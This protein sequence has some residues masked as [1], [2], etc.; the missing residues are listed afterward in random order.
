ML[1]FSNRNWAFFPLS[2]INISENTVKMDI[3]FLYLCILNL[4]EVILISKLMFR[5]VC[6]LEFSSSCNKNSKLC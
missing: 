1:F 5:F 4:A 6:S 2:L 3:L